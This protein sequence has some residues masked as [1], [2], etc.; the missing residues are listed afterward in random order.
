MLPL[1]S[2][3]GL[4]VIGGATSASVLFLWW[5]LRAETRDEAREAAAKGEPASLEP[6]AAPE[7]DPNGV[8]PG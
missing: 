8:T 1:A 7:A 3:S 5:L 4:A 2:A 6:Q